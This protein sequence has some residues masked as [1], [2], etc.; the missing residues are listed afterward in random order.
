M[1][2]LVSKVKG[3]T[4][5][6]VAIGLAISAVVVATAYAGF[7]SNA[8]RNE[9]RANANTITEVISGA[10]KTFGSSPTG[11][12]NVTLNEL[13]TSNVIPK[14]M[15][16]TN[17]STTTAKN[18]YGGTIAL[19]STGNTREVLG[20]EWPSVPVKQCMDLAMALSNSVESLSVG[21]SQVKADRD[22]D[23]NMS[24]LNTAC[25]GSAAVNFSFTFAR[26]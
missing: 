22:T 19:A 24:S 21:S 4:L 25:T 18:S 1:K 6:E 3:L 5:V 17:G 14:S 20:L 16:E 12:D 13:L 11:Y 9:V 8:R 26:T 2:K 7:E 23:I 10:K 15:Q